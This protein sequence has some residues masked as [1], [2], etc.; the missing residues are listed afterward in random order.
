MTK[1]IINIVFSILILVVPNQLMAQNFESPYKKHDGI[2]F[3]NKDGANS[4]D[5]FFFRISGG[6][7]SY[8]LLNLDSMLVDKSKYVGQFKMVPSK[9]SIGA[10]N[11][12]IGAGPANFPLDFELGFSYRWMLNNSID[13]SK[14][15]TYD[16]AYDDQFAGDGDL[17]YYIALNSAYWHL[18]FMLGCPLLLGSPE[19]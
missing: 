12:D 11:F 4:K 18:R 17:K 13:S 9:R 7:D 8:G 14:T 16:L 19:K 6:R 10:I 15:Q 3:R 2:W 5:R 1:Y